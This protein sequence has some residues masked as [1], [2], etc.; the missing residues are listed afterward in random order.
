MVGA[1]GVAIRRLLV[2]VLADV[3]LLSSDGAF[4]LTPTAGFLLL[5]ADSSDFLLGFW[6]VVRIGVL[7]V[8]APARTGKNGRGGRLLPRDDD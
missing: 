7:F 5:L 1:G 6:F 4:R 8:V 3:P 2:A